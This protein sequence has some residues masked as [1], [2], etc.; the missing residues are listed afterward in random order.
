MRDRP[1]VAGDPGEIEQLRAFD[2][3]GHLDRL[4]QAPA[5]RSTRPVT[6]LD[7]DRE[8]PIL[9]GVADP[10][11]RRATPRVESTRHTSSVVSSAMS[12]AAHRS[13]PGSVSSFASSTRRTRP[14]AAPAPVA[15]AALIPQPPASSC[16]HQSWGAMVVLACGAI[17]TPCCP[18]YPAI[19]RT[20]CSSAVRRSTRT[21]GTRS[22]NVHPGPRLEQ[23]DGLRDRGNPLVVDP[24]RTS[25]SSASA[26]AALVMNGSAADDRGSRRGSR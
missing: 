17:D 26:P 7:E 19:N 3:A 10:S 24:T 18:Q 5:S 9:A 11:S 15:P 8:R 20:L 25:A 1:F 4:R 23:R 13:D 14:R 12:A 22:A 2:G 16:F 6:Q 21:G